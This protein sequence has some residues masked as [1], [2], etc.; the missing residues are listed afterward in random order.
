MRTNVLDM[1][2]TYKKNYFNDKDFKPGTTLFFGVTLLPFGD[3][4][5]TSNLIPS[6]GNSLF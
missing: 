4:Y 6:L 5:N 2:F 3:N 1:A